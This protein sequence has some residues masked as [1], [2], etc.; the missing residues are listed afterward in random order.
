MK[1]R[2]ISRIVRGRLTTDGAG[3]KLIRVLG[4]GDVQ[5]IDP[6]LMM[7]AFDATDP[8]DYIKGF[9][10]HPHR[11]IETITY[12]IEGVFTHRDSLGNAGQLKGG[13]AQWMT[14]GSGILHEEMPAVSNRLYGLQFWLNLPRAHKMTEP[15]YFDIT[16]DK[17]A[18][19]DIPGGRV[20]VVSGSYGG[21]SGVDP[22][23]VKA[24]MLDVTLDSGASAV[25]E[26]PAD[27]NGFVYALEG[28]GVFGGTEIPGKSAGILGA[29]DALS[30]EAGESG[31]RFM[32]LAADPLHQ[33]IAWA[34]PIVMNTQAELQQAF[35]ELDNG[36][37]VR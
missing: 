32:L 9:P 11:G 22:K 21:V 37:F 29:G 10:M 7:D 6:F 34:G 35:F 13:E 27:K 3:V 24:L 8:A 36:T 20:R 15:A 16:A 19:V 28:A 26:I 1:E 12:L 4:R 18:G 5:D 23:Y 31:V 30:V 2:T 14:S 25:F 17:I 33:P